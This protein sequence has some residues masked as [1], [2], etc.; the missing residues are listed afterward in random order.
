MHKQSAAF[1][2]AV[3]RDTRRYRKSSSSSK[4]WDKEGILVGLAEIFPLNT[5]LL[6]WLL[7]NLIFFFP[8][9]LRHFCTKH[10][11]LTEPTKQE[12]PLSSAICIIS[13][14]GKCHRMCLSKIL[15]QRPQVLSTLQGLGPSLTALRPGKAPQKK[16]NNGQEWKSRMGNEVW[17]GLWEQNGTKLSGALAPQRASPNFHFL[18]F[19]IFTE[20]TNFSYRK[21]VF[22][23]VLKL[24]FKLRKFQV[25]VL[26]E[27]ILLK[28]AQSFKNKEKPQ[29]PEKLNIS[30]V[31]KVI[32][33]L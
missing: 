18:S 14:L 11:L 20:K 17:A 25:F 8:P 31:W 4:P 13:T 22:Q 23:L 7:T 9:K 19:K 5:L 32:L 24:S 3:Q 27:I 6:T 1:G 10:Q 21:S 12:S 29:D 15:V 30:H 16:G 28:L 33:S 26:A 2:G